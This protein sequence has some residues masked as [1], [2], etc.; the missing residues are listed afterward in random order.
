MTSEEDVKKLFVK[1]EERTIGG[2]K[3]TIK[4]MSLDQISLPLCRSST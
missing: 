4:Q 1:T 3:F 2:V